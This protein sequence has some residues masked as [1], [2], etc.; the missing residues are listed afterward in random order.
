MKM[1]FALAIEMFENGPK[2]FSS[3]ND[4]HRPGPSRVQ[5]LILA[6]FQKKI[7]SNIVHTSCGLINRCS[8]A[9]ATAS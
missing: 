1:L 9:I 2:D 4:S 7:S 3:P 6:R 5:S 8:G